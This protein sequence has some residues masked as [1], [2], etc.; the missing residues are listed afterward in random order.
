[1]SKKNTGLCELLE[2]IV[3]TDDIL[4]TL[5]LARA[6]KPQVKVLYQTTMDQ[7]RRMNDGW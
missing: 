6:L 4:L 3:I 7:Y 5:H 1:M 2:L